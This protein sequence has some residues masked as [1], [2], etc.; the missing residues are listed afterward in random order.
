MNSIAK[1]N[2][3]THNV[4]WRRKVNQHQ[5]NTQLNIK[6]FARAGIRFREPFAPKGD[7]LPLHHRVN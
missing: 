2:F 4:L 1:V 5:Q 3:E 6:V 7:A